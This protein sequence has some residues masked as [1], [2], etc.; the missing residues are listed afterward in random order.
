MLHYKRAVKA[1]RMPNEL[2]KVSYRKESG[3]V[4]HKPYY[5]MEIFPDD[6]IQYA[7]LGVLCHTRRQGKLKVRLQLFWNNAA[8]GRLKELQISASENKM[9]RQP[10]KHTV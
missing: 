9:E 6:S 1:A 3:A 5:V 4:A 8:N 10:V 2:Q 7:P